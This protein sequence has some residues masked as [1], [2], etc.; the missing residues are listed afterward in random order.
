MSRKEDNKLD[1]SLIELENVVHE[2]ENYCEIRKTFDWMFD[3]P[4]NKIQ[5]LVE[6][7]R[8]LEEK[9]GRNVSTGNNGV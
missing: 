7:A 8:D 2:L 6:Q 1:R 9:Y 4:M 3:R 5:E